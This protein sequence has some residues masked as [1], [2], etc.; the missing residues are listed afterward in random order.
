[1]LTF[2]YQTHRQPLLFDPKYPLTGKKQPS[3]TLPHRK[4]CLIKSFRNYVLSPGLKER[5]LLLVKRNYASIYVLTPQTTGYMMT[6]N[7]TSLNRTKADM[8]TTTSVGRVNAIPEELI[9]Q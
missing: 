8:P 5:L 9:R 3:Y 4:Q 6:D 1:M 2:L 7:N